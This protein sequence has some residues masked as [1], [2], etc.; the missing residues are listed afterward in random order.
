MTNKLINVP[1]RNL[2]RNRPMAGINNGRASRGWIGEEGVEKREKG[3]CASSNY[4]R[5][6]GIICLRIVAA[7]HCCA[8]KRSTTIGHH[9]SLPLL[10]LSIRLD[11]FVSPAVR[12][13]G[14]PVSGF[15]THCIFCRPP[16]S[17]VNYIPI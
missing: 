2:T 13:V 5:Y 10:I 3:P 1:P 17:L 6:S 9:P 12:P 16:S 14:S 15:Q 7:K 8:A 11:S 4:D